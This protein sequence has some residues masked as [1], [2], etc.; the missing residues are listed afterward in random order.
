MSTIIRIALLALVIPVATFAL[1]FFTAKLLREV[2]RREPMPVRL[3][4]RRP[5]LP[6]LKERI[7]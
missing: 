5:A 3:S 4:V 2:A 7:R 1:L 6:L